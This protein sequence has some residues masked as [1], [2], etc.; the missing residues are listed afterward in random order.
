MLK[1]VFFLNQILSRSVFSES[2]FEQ[3]SKSDFDSLI[4]QQLEKINAVTEKYEKIASSKLGHLTSEQ[5][6]S[7]YGG[8]EFPSSHT[9]VCE[10]DIDSSFTAPQLK[11]VLGASSTQPILASDV[12]LQSNKTAKETKPKLNSDRSQPTKSKGI[13]T[14]QAELISNAMYQTTDT[15]YTETNQ[16]F[17]TTGYSLHN[18]VWLL[19]FNIVQNMA[20]HQTVIT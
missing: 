3:K 5:L 15:T 20:L 14:S 8:S 17:I 12:R 1:I 13:L 9:S 10:D 6:F 4:R 7:L 16:L 18:L 11:P 19:H 2:N